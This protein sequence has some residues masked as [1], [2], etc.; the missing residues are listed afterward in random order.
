MI[1]CHLGSGAGITAIEYG[2]SVET[3]MGMTPL[4]GLI[5]GTRAGDLDPGIVLELG[6]MELNIHCI[7]RIGGRLASPV[8]R[9]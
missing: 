2:R 5:M 9:G 8:A 3:S 4:E 6:V 7:D 1:S